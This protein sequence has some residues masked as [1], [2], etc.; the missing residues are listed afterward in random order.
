MSESISE[1]KMYEIKVLPK[2]EVLDS[3]GRATQKVLEQGGFSLSRCS[4]GRYIEIEC[5]E[6]IEEIKKMANYVLFNPLI[7]DIEVQLKSK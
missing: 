3:Q 4:V 6:S 2:K 7:E 1:K 5:A